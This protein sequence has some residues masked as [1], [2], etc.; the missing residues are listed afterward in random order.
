MAGLHVG[1]M[2]TGG[3]GIA[4]AGSLLFQGLA[5]RLTLYSRSRDKAWGEA[6]DYLHAMP[7]LPTAEVRAL[8]FDEVEPED[9][10]ILA[11][12]AH[13]EPGQSRLDVLKENLEVIMVTA[14][15]IERGALPRVVIV[16]TNPLDVLTEYLT[17][18]W[19]GKPVSVMGTGTSLDTLRFTE[20]LARECGVHPRSVHAWVV[21]EHG[22]SSVFLFS[23][24]RVGAMSL[25][26]FASQR[27][28]DL[29]SEWYAGIEAEVHGAA[30]KVIERTGATR[31]GIG[32]TVSGLVRCIGREAGTLIPVSVRVA[33]DV[34]ASLP[35]ALGPD[36]AGEPLMPK[37][38]EGELAAWE[39]SLA[40]L[41]AADEILPI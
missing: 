23:G 6:L 34:C 3:V 27:K 14:D 2:G 24:A 12:G 9:V 20:A 36:G 32:L 4:T 7:L 13:T 22:D 10:L 29:T 15:A 18:R 8:S 21:G 5:G 40:V 19:A 37:M 1:I 30:Y 28:M 38:D 17:R 31:H 33:R 16:V 25:T 26:D 35:C 41:R 39:R 11:V